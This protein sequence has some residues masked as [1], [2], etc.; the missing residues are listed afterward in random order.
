M[1]VSGIASSSNPYATA[2]RSAAG[3]AVSSQAKSGATGKNGQ[4][5]AEEQDQV[6]QLK[7]EDRKVRAH[8]Q[9]HL[10]AAGGL[11]TSGANYTY[12][13]GP[14]GVNYAVGGEVSIDTSAGRTPEET[15]RKAQTIRAAALAPADPSGP[16][17]AIAAEASQM[18][19]Q[20]SAE[21]AQESQAPAGQ[22]NGQAA[23]VGGSA[24]GESNPVSRYYGAV[25]ATG[26]SRIDTYA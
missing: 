26:N 22:D 5:S 19:L 18:A 1:N 11:A 15:L 4:L 17:R 7:A 21:L 2:L 16:D 20:A 9:A 12:Q 6:R 24:T 3:S 14:D 10:A 8:E 13:R 25:G 23:A